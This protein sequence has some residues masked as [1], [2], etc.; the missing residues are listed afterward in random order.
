MKTF[1][2]L[3]TIFLLNSCSSD[4]NTKNN[5][6]NAGMKNNMQ[7]DYAIAIHGGSGTI[8][9]GNLS[10][11]KEKAVLQTLRDALKIGENILKAGGKSMDA[12]EKTIIYLENSPF[13]NAGKGA[14]YT[15]AGEHELDAS[16]MDGATQNAGAVGGVKTIKNPILAAR[17]VMDKSPH[18][19]LTGAG[20]D[21]FAQAQG[22]ETVEQ[23]YFH[24]EHR[25][26]S[27]QKA[28][29]AGNKTGMISESE[30]DYKFGTV[31]CVALDKSGNLAA[32]TSTG[33]MTNKR[34]NRLGDSPIIGAGTYADNKT[35]A[36]SSTGHGEF[37][38]RY[39]VAHDIA[40]LMDYKKMSL[41]AAANFVINEKL[42]E[43][44]G[45][46]GVIAVD[47]FGNVAMPFNT[48]GMYRGYAKR[49]ES[50]VE[51]YK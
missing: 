39:V 36:V 3:I 16:I 29:E 10:E 28:K 9:K 25:L 43:K 30:V 45:S 33:G 47:R 44:G 5:T 46:G 21:A 2:L 15:N 41:D 35:C 27:L 8:L 37:F 4:K 31:G 40:A 38:M 32:G 17:A 12:V 34:Y 13:F 23:D 6:I 18:V 19:L 22:L 48:A 42:K 49:G 20:A 11:E 26:Q 7:S 24:T 51:I 14:V 50:K 1:V